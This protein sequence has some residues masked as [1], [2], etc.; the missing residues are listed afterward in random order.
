MLRRRRNCASGTTTNWKDFDEF[1][2][3]YQAELS[4]SP[5][6]EELRELAKRGVVTLVTAT[7]ELDVSHAAAVWRLCWGALKCDWDCM[8]WESVPAPIAR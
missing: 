7:R 2:A 4:G 5:A 6:L 8:R 3:R 1:A